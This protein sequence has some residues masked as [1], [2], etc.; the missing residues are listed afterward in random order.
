[1]AELIGGTFEIRSEAGKGTRVLMEIPLPGE[2]RCAAASGSAEVW[3]A[4]GPPILY[5][6]TSLLLTSSYA[7][8]GVA[9]HEQP[10]DTR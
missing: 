8:Y 1:M 3:I 6:G 10:G 7:G 5:L 2:R 4:K 9:G